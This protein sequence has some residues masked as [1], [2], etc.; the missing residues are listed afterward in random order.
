MKCREI[1]MGPSIRTIQCK[2]LCTALWMEYPF[3]MLKQEQI[4]AGREF[5]FLR[6]CPCTS[7]VKGKE[8]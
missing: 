1:S 2:M 5:F 4:N 8:N 3:K 7:V 6:L